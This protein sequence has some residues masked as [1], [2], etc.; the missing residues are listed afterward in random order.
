MKSSKKIKVEV[1]GRYAR[2]DDQMTWPM[3]DFSDATGNSLEWTLRYGTPTKEQ[4]LTVASYLSAYSHMVG[5]TQK[6]RNHICTAIKVA[7][8]ETK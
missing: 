6:K 4:L 2:I 8:K 1:W 5:L 3:P 7:L